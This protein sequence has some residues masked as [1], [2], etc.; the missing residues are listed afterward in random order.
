LLSD[1]LSVGVSVDVDAGGTY[2]TVDASTASL[3]LDGKA[4]GSID[5]AAA[6]R[7]DVLA[8]A[9]K[10]GSLRE[11]LK[12][13]LRLSAST[14]AF[15]DV[16]IVRFTVNTVF[17]QQGMDDVWRVSPDALSFQLEPP[18]TKSDAIEVTVE[19]NAPYPLVFNLAQDM[20]LSV[21]PASLVVPAGGT[22][23]FRLS[24]LLPPQTDCFSEETRR[25]GTIA[26]HATFQGISSKKTVSADV[27]VADFAQACKPQNGVQVSLP[28]DSR[29][30]FAPGSKI[31]QNPDGSNSVRLL[32]GQMLW[33]DAGVSVTPVEASVPTDSSFILSRQFVQTLPE[34]GWIIA[35]P[36][37]VVLSLPDD[38]DR[39]PV[40]GTTI[41]TLSNAQIVLPPGVRGVEPQAIGPLQPVSRDVFV[42]P[43]LP[44]TFRRIPYNYDALNALLPPNPVEVQLPVEAVFDLP[45]GTVE[46]KTPNTVNYQNLPG[47]QASERLAGVKGV[48]LPGGEKLA[49]GVDALVDIGSLKVRLP[50]KASLYVDGRRLRQYN[51]EPVE[52]A[53]ELTLPVP[54][55][56]TVTGS[57]TPVRSAGG[58][59]ALKLSEDGA[60]QT[61]FNPAISKDGAKSVVRIVRE[62]PVVFLKGALSRVPTDPDALSSC[63][64][65]YNSNQNYAFDLPEG[66]AVVKVNG[67][68]KAVLP[69]CDSTAQLTF[70]AYGVSEQET[71][72]FQ[73]PAVR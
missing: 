13:T 46:R 14:G 47:R 63:T 38:A 48:Q 66:T 50:E 34:G 43:G 33:F 36:A 30:G 3:R 58:G 62:N 18:K 61:A 55:A 23:A 39:Q 2:T 7:D 64:L 15:S 42:P 4:S 17:A 44:V 22:D 57:P 12:G 27:D 41:I 73:T 16:Q 40:S 25:D 72:L 8:V 67:G 68:Y 24:A 65:S 56:L 20:G 10:A 71:K 21:Q 28:V 6:V 59:Y 53:F 29:L 31:H 37:E 9:K 49:F 52:R 11:T 1:R 70:T 19:N 5:L 45:P 54:Y 26:V 35:F 60:I 51:Q 69:E 32:S